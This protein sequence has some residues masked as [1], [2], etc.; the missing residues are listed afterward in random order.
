MVTGAAS[1]T[2]CRISQS[3]PG[4]T[5]PRQGQGTL[6][7]RSTTQLI[8]TPDPKVKW[9]ITDKRFVERTTNG[10]RTWQGQELATHADLLAGS[11]PSANVCWVVG[12]NGAVY[13]AKNAHNPN[14]VIWNKAAAPASA[15]LVAVSA[16][17]ARYA[18]V[19]TTDGRQFETHDGGK[20]WKPVSGSH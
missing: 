16:K 20:E 15:D 4:E 14:K 2:I 19:A 13:V 6:A 5:Q 11:A 7:Q 8:G 3:H 9:R 10:G 18:V 1:G 17:S 12:R